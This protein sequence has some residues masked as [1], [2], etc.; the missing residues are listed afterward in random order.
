M[1]GLDFMM[2]RIAMMRKSNLL[3]VTAMASALALAGCA[4]AQNNPKTT[5]GAIIGGI[6]GALLGSMFEACVD[7]HTRGSSRCFIQHG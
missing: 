7:V 6:G 1:S 5:G 3:M 2:T 4:D